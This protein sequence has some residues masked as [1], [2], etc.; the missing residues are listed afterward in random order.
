MEPG[1]SISEEEHHDWYGNEHA[2]ARLTIPSFYTATR[3]KAADGLK[4]TYLTLYDISEAS[5]ADGP[6]YQAVKA[7]ASEREKRLM[8]AIQFANRRTYTS[9]SSH[10]HPNAT[11]DFPPKFVFVFGMDVKPEGEADLNKWY[12]EEH[13]PMMS[14]I[15]G[16]L[17]TRRYILHSSTARG[18]VDPEVSVHKYMAIHD[19]SKSGYMETPEMKAASSTP[20][21]DQVAQGVLGVE[22]RH[23]ELFKEYK[24]PE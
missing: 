24:R 8:E 14:K 7:N 5:V 21:R 18:T 1:P 16:W 23:L 6:E 4:P 12:E 15:P 13:T 17:R 22:V 2:P 11:A 3:F 19:F 9:I 10:T 20:W